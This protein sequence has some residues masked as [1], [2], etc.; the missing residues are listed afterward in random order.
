MEDEEEETAMKKLGFEIKSGRAIKPFICTGCKREGSIGG[1]YLEVQVMDRIWGPICLECWHKV[2][3]MF[4]TVAQNPGV[5]I[6]V[7]AIREQV[8]SHYL[9]AKSRG[10]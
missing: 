3:R 6:D 2:P 5:S 10:N 9:A 8:R 4:E 1:D 7:E